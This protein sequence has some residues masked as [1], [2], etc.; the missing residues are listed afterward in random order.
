[1]APEPSGDTLGPMLFCLAIQP[2]V[3]KLKS[4][5]NIWYLDDGTIGGDIEVVIDDVN[6]IVS[7]SKAIGLEVNVGKCEIF[8]RQ[9]MRETMYGCFGSQAVVHKHSTWAAASGQKRSLHWLIGV[10][11][12]RLRWAKSKHP[13]C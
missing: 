6:T 9:A 11:I 3:D 10:G 1:M 8:S 5:L 2:V 13:R 4:P 7:A 12:D